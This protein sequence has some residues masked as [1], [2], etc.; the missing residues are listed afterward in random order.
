MP[1]RSSGNPSCE[2]HEPSFQQLWT[3]G[4]RRELLELWV[5]GMSLQM[6]ADYFQRTT[7]DVVRELASL[8]LQVDDLRS[9]STTPR[10]GV[11]WS[12]DDDHMLVQQ[13]Q[14]G[15]TLTEIAEALGRDEMGAAF[16]MLEYFA[17]G[18]PR[19]TIER[20]GLADFAAAKRREAGDPS[21]DAPE[22]CPNCLD[23][24]LYCKCRIGDDQIY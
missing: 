16:R 23:V 2:P 15:V 11:R 7:R 6:L 14:L 13:H 10:H 24:V 18:I 1:S 20:F 22:T 19:E 9:D 4:T 12:W 21:G 8:I 5:D 3:D 17:P